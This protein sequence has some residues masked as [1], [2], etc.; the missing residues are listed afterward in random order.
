MRVASD[1]EGPPITW[2]R[3]F[4]NLSVSWGQ[5]GSGTPLIIPVHPQVRPVVA[6]PD[7]EVSTKLAPFP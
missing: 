2:L 7:Y 5:L 3:R 1:M 6:V 4:G